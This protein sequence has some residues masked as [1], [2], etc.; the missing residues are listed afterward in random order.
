MDVRTRLLP[1]LVV[2]FP[3]TLVGCDGSAGDDTSAQAAPDTVEY[4]GPCTPYQGEK[5]TTEPVRISLEGDEVK[6]TPERPKLVRG[7][8]S[9]RWEATNVRHWIV[10]APPTR[11]AVPFDR[12]SFGPSADGGVTEVPVHPYVDCGTYKF[13]VVVWDAD[14]QRLVAEDPPV[15]IVPGW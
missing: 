3:L 10:I 14:N 6:V 12:T 11:G 9:L 5:A 1:F 8:G 13:G 15:D 2:L 7:K 4:R